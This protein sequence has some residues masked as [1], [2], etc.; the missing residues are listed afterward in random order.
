MKLE[1]LLIRLCRVLLVL[2]LSL[3]AIGALFMGVSAYYI[4]KGVRAGGPDCGLSSACRSVEYLVEERP[5]LMKTS[6]LIT[7]APL[8]NAPSTDNQNRSISQA[9]VG[10]RLTEGTLDLGNGVISDTLP[11]TEPGLLSP[12]DLVTSPLFIN[13]ADDPYTSTAQVHPRTEQCPT[14]STASFE[15][16]PVQGPPPDHPDFAHADLN[17]SLRGYTPVSASLKMV[18]YFGMTG[19][20]SPQLPGLFHPPRVPVFKIAYQ[21]NQW[22]WAS[23]PCDGHAHGC[24]GEP[25]TDWDATLLSLATR[26][27]EMI[28]IPDRGAEIY[29]GGFK[30]LVLYAEERQITLGYSRSD[31]VATGYVVHLKDVCVDPNLLALYRA[32]RDTDGWHVTGMLPALRNEQVL[33]VAAGDEIKVAVRDKGS[34]MDPRSRKDWWQ[35]H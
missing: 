29:A 21:V 4:D 10:P 5:R 35:G 15:L 6:V 31:T 17:L 23:D 9:T 25:I 30:A 1:R 34:F 22:I 27:G 16:I 13:T 32:Q 7:P 8:K 20:D 18:F 33:G 26:P 11:I 28:S 2:G 19:E 24:P 12:S 3:V 14:T